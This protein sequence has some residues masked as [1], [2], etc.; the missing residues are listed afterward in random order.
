[1]ALSP[2]LTV[3]RHLVISL[4]ARVLEE[5]SAQKSPKISLFRVVSGSLGGLL[6]L[7]SGAFNFH[8]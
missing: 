7:S 4:L 1:M 3:T 5:E 2:P 6:P 8:L